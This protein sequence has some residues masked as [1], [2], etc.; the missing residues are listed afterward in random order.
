MQIFA[1]AARNSQRY[2]NLVSEC[3]AWL[4][5]GYADTYITLVL[6]LPWIVNEELWWTRR[7]PGASL[8]VRFATACRGIGSRM[9]VCRKSQAL[10]GGRGAL[11][12]S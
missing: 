12:R 10:P 9:E 5:T 3:A 2:A 1:G 8:V 11:R 6:R 4:G 7:V